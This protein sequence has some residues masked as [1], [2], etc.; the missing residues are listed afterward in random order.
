M[1]TKKVSNHYEVMNVNV[2]ATSDEIKRKYRELAK[3]FH[4]DHAADKVN[5]HQTFS[6]INHAYRV[7][8]DPE[9]RKAYDMELHG[10]DHKPH[11]RAATPHGNGVPSPAVHRSTGAPH[12]T[13]SVTQLVQLLHDADHALVLGKVRPGKG[14]LRANPRC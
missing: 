1:H 14:S 2:D 4:P 5:A 9:Q 7:L 13:V 3:K 12:A 8:V 11:I 6:Q 10:K